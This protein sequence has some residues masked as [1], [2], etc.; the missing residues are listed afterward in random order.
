MLSLRDRLCLTGEDAAIDCGEIFT[1]TYELSNGNGK[2]V[3]KEELSKAEEILDTYLVLLCFVQI[4]EDLIN[5][6]VISIDR[7][8][9]R[10]DLADGG[11]NVLLALCGLVAIATSVDHLKLCHYFTEFSF[12]E[13]ENFIN[14]KTM[15]KQFQK[16]ET[17]SMRTANNYFRTR[18]YSMKKDLLATSNVEP[19][20]YDNME[21]QPKSD[22]E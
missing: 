20:L 15:K 21:E 10:L 11:L 4:R 17:K 12:F 1:T 18:M 9:N 7:F 14:N 19:Q 16:K 13:F 5:F 6:H 3:L 22:P 8:D 2:G